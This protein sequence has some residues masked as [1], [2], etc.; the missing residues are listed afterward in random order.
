MKVQVMREMGYEEALLG[1]SLSYNQPVENMPAVAMKLLPKGGSET[2][3]LESINI[4]LDITAPRFWWQQMDTYRAGISKQSESTM[5]TL[6]KRP[7]TASDFTALVQ[8]AVIELL[9]QMIEDKDWS[10]VKENLPEGFLQRRVVAMNYKALR[11]IIDQRKD[12]RLA[13]WRVFIDAVL[14]QA[15]HPEFLEVTT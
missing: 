13:E 12:H 15:E 8:P 4:W 1:L 2:K 6:L 10:T 14:E 7:L 9:N 5:H 3:F 11:H